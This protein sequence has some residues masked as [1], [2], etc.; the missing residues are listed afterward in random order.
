MTASPAVE[1]NPTDWVNEHIERYL[2]TG[3]E[4]GHDY[5]G[6]PTLLLT[7]RGRRSGTLRRTALI[8][9]EDN[10]RLVLVAS[11]AAAPVHPNW[12]HNLVADPVVQVQVR[13]ETFDAR[14]DRG[15]RPRLWQLM[16]SIFPT[17]LQYASQTEREIPVVVLHRN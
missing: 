12:Y 11:N 16:T 8:Y 6:F 7:T 5:H 10:D 15:E 1:N 4:S 2:A 14:A 9:G 13:A 17:Y 3:G